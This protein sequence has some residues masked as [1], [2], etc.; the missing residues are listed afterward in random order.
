MEMNYSRDDH[1]AWLRGPGRAQLQEA[2]EEIQGKGFE[3]EE[4]FEEEIAMQ[5]ELFDRCH[6]LNLRRL[7]S[8]TEP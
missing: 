3:N 7:Q 1:E 4:E 2:R 8:C 6:T 5:M